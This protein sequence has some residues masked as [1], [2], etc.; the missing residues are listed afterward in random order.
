MTYL[1][2]VYSFYRQISIP[3][4]DGCISVGV[5]ITFLQP[6][7]PGSKV[8]STACKGT[9]TWWLSTAWKSRSVWEFDAFYCYSCVSKVLFEVIIVRILQSSNE[10][11]CQI[12]L[13]TLKW[14]DHPSQRTIKFWMLS[15]YLLNIRKEIRHKLRRPIV[16]LTKK[17]KKDNFYRGEFWQLD[18]FP[19]YLKRFTSHPRSFISMFVAGLRPYI[20]ISYR[21]DNR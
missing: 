4:M 8:E 2:L 5:S 3:K 19:C 15:N 18:F 13:E 9:Q 7:K 16:F 12:H 10:M 11:I 1:Q 17:N 20:H 21:K 6:V 14:T